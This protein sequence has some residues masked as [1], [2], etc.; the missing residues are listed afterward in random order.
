MQNYTVGNEIEEDLKSA[1]S[2]RQ[3]ENMKSSSKL[4]FTRENIKSFW[5]CCSNML[6]II[7]STTLWLS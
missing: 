3:K 7:T 1:K 4:T 2:F 5:K 6:W